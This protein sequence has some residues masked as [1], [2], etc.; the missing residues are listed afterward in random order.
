MKTKLRVA[1][2]ATGLWI[3]QCKEYRK[4]DWKRHSLLYYGDDITALKVVDNLVNLY[5]NE[6]ERG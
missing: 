6:Y 4:R 5:S 2:D 3:I 1:H